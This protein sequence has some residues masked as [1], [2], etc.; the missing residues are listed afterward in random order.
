VDPGAVAPGTSADPGAAGAVENAVPGGTVPGGTVPG[1]QPAAGGGGGGAKPGTDAK[2]Q[3]TNVQ[4]RNTGDCSKP[5]VIGSVGEYS[6]VLGSIETS[7]TVLVRS[8]A[9]AT[10]AA[11][12]LNCKQV[13]YVVYDAGGDPSREQA[14][15]RKAVEEDK[16]IAFVYMGHAL[17]GQ[18]AVPYLE[19]KQVPVIGEEG[20]NAWGCK[21]P[22]WFPVMSSCD[23]GVDGN[24]QVLAKAVG[25]KDN[26]V[27][28]I[29]CVEVPYCAAYQDKGAGYAKA[30]GLELVYNGKISLTQPDY[31]SQCLFAQR[32]GASMVV[33]GGDSTAMSR[34]LT[35]CKSVNYA[36]ILTG[37][38]SA[39]TPA[40][41]SVPELEGAWTASGTKV[42]PA[43]DPAI[44]ALLAVLKRYAPQ[45]PLGPN[46]SIGWTSA[47]VFEYALR[48]VTGNPTSQD[49]LNGLWSIKNYDVNGMTRPLTYT[50][51]KPYQVEPR[52]WFPLQIKNKQWTGPGKLCA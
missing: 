11:G 15:V 45:E 17:A 8:W 41:P 24:Y 10:N 44:A 50:K 23:D 21:S 14:L 42:A 13:K 27:A 39:F 28:A 26:K 35:S 40:A 30:N 47:K 43:T 9:A 49:V 22:M 52:C 6:G 5:I 18:A 16:V 20:G 37:P 51:G 4:A 34:F 31:T 29:T 46:G 12:G 25:K 2:G 3:V 7:G 48:N 38:G 33:F 32:A 36:P 1:Q 19:Q